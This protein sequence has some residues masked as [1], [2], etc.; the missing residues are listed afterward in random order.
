MNG[1]SAVPAGACHARLTL[2]ALLV[3]G[4][5]AWHEV[6]R[7]DPA[8]FL[9]LPGPPERIVNAQIAIVSD[10]ASAQF[11]YEWT[12]G[13]LTIPVGA[14]VDA[15]AVAA[16]ADETGMPVVQYSSAQAATDGRASTVPMTMIIV[17]PA[18]FEVHDESI[19][20]VIPY[21]FAVPLPTRESVR[22]IVD[23]Q[24]LDATGSPLWTRRY[25]SGEATYTET[26][27]ERSTRLGQD[28]EQRFYVQLAHQAAY[29]LM[30]EAALDLRNWLEA[31][32]LR[33]RVL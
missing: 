2:V 14:I 29:R 20:I 24:V 30:R 11:M 21:F 15:A 31:E 19:P 26:P 1:R 13:S 5:A 33:E 3:A 12:K 9:R 4:C 16:L 32:R 28:R 27:R 22:L 25:D 18:R 6:G 17:R 23:W 8:L 7:L 10:P